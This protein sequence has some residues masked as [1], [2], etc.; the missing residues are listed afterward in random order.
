MTKE[1]VNFAETPNAFSPTENTPH[2]TINHEAAVD[3][4]SSNAFEGTI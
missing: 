1:M 3:L 2:I 4:D